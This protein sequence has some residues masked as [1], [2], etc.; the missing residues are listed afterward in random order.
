MES[1]L[2]GQRNRYAT[3]SHCRAVWPQVLVTQDVNDNRSNNENEKHGY[4]KP[5]LHLLLHLAAIHGLIL[6]LADLGYG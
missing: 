4:E 1:R 6:A 3:D 5:F 2:P